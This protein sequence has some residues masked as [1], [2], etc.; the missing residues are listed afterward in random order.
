MK[1]ETNQKTTWA[2]A[3]G[4]AV[5]LAV[6]GAWAGFFN[7][8]FDEYLTI[9]TNVVDIGN[10]WGASSNNVMVVGP[11]AF[12]NALVNPANQVAR[13]APGQFMTNGV[14]ASATPNWIWTEAWLNATNFSAF[15]IP[16]LVNTAAVFMVAMATNANG[17]LYACNPTTL[18]WEACST[19]ATN[20][21][22]VQITTGGWVRVSVFQ[23]Y[24]AHLMTLFVNGLPLRKD[25]PFIN[26]NLAS[27]STLRFTGSADGNVDVDTV[28]VS[29]NT[30]SG[31]TSDINNNGLEDGAEL[32]SYGALNVWTGST[33][34]ATVS[35]APGGTVTPS[36]AV[37]GIRYN[38]NTNFTLSAGKGY[39]VGPVWTNGV[40]ATNYT[41]AAQKSEI[42]N[43][44]NITTDGTFQVGFT[45]NGIRY[46]PGDYGTIS[47][48]VAAAQGGDVITLASSNYNEAV[49]VASNLTFTGTGSADL[50]LF[51]VQAGVTNALE[52][53][54]NFTAS[55]LT[56]ASNGVLMV[57]NSVLNLAA[58]TIQTNAFIYGYNS[59]ATVNG[60]EYTGDFILDEFWNIVLTAQPLNFSDG[61]DAYARGTRL[62]RL[63]N[64][65]WSAS[66]STVTVVEN[67][68][69]VN[70]A[71]ST[72]AAL[73]PGWAVVSNLISA[74]TLTPI[75]S[76]VMIRGTEWN[77]RPDLIDTNG[78]APVMFFV[79]TNGWLTVLTPSG[80]V[81]CSND[82]RG[83]S[84]AAPNLNTGTWAEISWCMDFTPPAGKVSYFVN[85][86][87]VRQGLPF[88]KWTTQYHGLKLKLDDASVWVDNV[89]IMTNLPPGVTNWPA[90][91]LD[92][93]Y[94]GIADAVELAQKGTINDTPWLSAPT[95]TAV[96]T[97]AATLGASVTNDGGAV[98]TS[99]GTVWDTNQNPTAHMAT[100]LG[101]ATAS[102]S[103]STNQTG[104]SPG[105]HYY[106]CGWAS[107]AMGLAYSTNGEFY[108][109]PIQV[110]N[111]TYVPVSDGFTIS[112]TADATSTGT[113]VLVKQGVAVTAEPED[114]SNY[115][116]TAAFGT[117]S[118]FLGS[119]NYIVYAGFGGTSVTVNNLVY[120]MPYTVAAYA[121]AGSGN[122]IQYRTNSPAT[123]PL[124]WPPQGTVFKIR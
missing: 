26:T 43:W 115:V 96:D 46:V 63:G 40:P 109:E 118:A 1:T 91:H 64:N 10:G 55:S 89:N 5:L 88:A 16:P 83:G 101:S 93:D 69:D 15:D 47:A 119:S 94:D 22:A 56:V 79:N 70:N 30:P 19:D 80:W 13:L 41:S 12:T 23:N 77:D 85:G 4:L 122:L 49:T 20:G 36:G 28:L 82:V 110:T 75:W 103:F 111:L 38:G 17:Y 59:T 50:A 57:S 27:Y 102:F 81:V 87:L 104:F 61:F 7:E 25:W 21:P 123:C 116:V 18:T 45:Y 113:V 71:V 34:T 14:N 114:G 29:T 39:V 11:V 68:S 120:G 9:P 67:L 108:A 124:Q 106:V 112:W 44:S 35:N 117:D 86:H 92:L 37:T 31:L 98:V 54:T 107:N 51:T 24:T 52:G 105:Q 121:F 84:W 76:D 78:T 58:L 3:A 53:F 99:W 60:V 48:A 72:N 42:F 62:D 97:N 33:V 8:T 95:V 66:T 74:T 90:G 6:P 32:T 2:V 65:G 100:I 73:V